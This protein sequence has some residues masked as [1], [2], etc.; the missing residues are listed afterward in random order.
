MELAHYV[1][2]CSM[3]KISHMVQLTMNEIGEIYSTFSGKDYNVT[4]QRV[5]TQGGMGSDNMNT[6][7]HGRQ[8]VK[9]MSS[10]LIV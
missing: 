7:Y 10:A 3:G 9:K 8:M 1:H 4:W 6:L 2:S 5:W